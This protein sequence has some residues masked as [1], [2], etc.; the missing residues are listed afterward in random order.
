MF[1]SS[2]IRLAEPLRR[3]IPSTSVAISGQQS[4]KQEDCTS[5]GTFF[6]KEYP[7]FG[8]DYRYIS[9]YITL[10]FFVRE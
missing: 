7:A 1:W 3:N 6:L 10:P 2:L 9:V 8:N 4:S 5:R